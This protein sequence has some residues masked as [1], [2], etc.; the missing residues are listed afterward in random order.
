MKQDIMKN[1]IHMKELLDNV[2]ILLRW[3]IRNKRKNL[4]KIKN[5]KKKKR[6][7]NIKKKK[8]KKRIKKEIDLDLDHMKQNPL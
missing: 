1:P 7:K 3:M 2:M 5:I 8:K 4:K 6:I